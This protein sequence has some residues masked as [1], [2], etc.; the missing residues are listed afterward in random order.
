MRPPRYASIK[1]V[2]VFARDSRSL[3]PYLGRK[4]WGHNVGIL[5]EPE[6]VFI[7]DQNRYARAKFL[8]E[9]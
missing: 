4:T 1:I 6:T 7:Q 5:V 2:R 9:P 3:I 8:D